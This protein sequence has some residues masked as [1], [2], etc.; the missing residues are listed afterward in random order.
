[1]IFLEPW[2]AVVFLLLV[3]RWPTTTTAKFVRF[4]DRGEENDTRFFFGGEIFFWRSTPQK[5]K[6]DT[7]KIA[8]FNPILIRVRLPFPK[9]IILGVQ[10]LVFGGVYGVTS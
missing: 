10:Q 8:M 9:P 2:R 6:I 4:F 3:G 1:M 5:S 7:P